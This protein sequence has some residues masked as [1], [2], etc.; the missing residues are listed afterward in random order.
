MK[1]FRPVAIRDFCDPCLLLAGLLLMPALA[2]AQGLSLDELMGTPQPAAPGVTPSPASA[3][4]RVP[5]PASASLDLSTIEAGQ[6]VVRQRNA[7]ADLQTADL[8][9]SNQCSCVSSNSCFDLGYNLQYEQVRNAASKAQVSLHDTLRTV[10]QSWPGVGQPNQTMDMIATRRKI[11][12]KIQTALDQVN[13]SATDLSR[14]LAQQDNE[15]RQA[16]ARQ[17]EAANPGFNWGQFTA[18]TVGVVA[19][20]IGNLDVTQQAEILT[21]ITMDSM[22]GGGTMNS[23]QG[24]MESLNAELASMQTQVQVDVPAG[25]EGYDLNAS[26]D[27][28]MR[29]NQMMN[30][31]AED[32][33]RTLMGEQVDT[34]NRSYQLDTSS[35]LDGLTLS[36]DPSEPDYGSV[37]SSASA[38]GF[39]PAMRPGGATQYD[40]VGNSSGIQSTSTPGSNVASRDDTV[41]NETYRFTC[42]SGTQSQPIPI[43]ADSRVCAEAMK[44]FAKVYSCNLFEEYEA[45]QLDMNRVCA[46]NMFE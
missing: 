23:F 10:C 35:L 33:A 19:G 6:A 44:R 17:Q 24:T 18:M 46:S 15:I 41:I 4:N 27:N 40:S 28:M 26:A 13:S 31:A 14:Q 38:N 30:E 22:N 34:S 32:M 12:G 7:F 42:P 25:W 36:G 2:L 11:A 20:G 21:S 39:D 45:A 3:P 43:V 29:K 16:I 5:D 9:I 8:R 37:S 1:I